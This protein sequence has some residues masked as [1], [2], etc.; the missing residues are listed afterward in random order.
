M[1][2]VSHFF[3][4]LNVAFSLGS[5]DL[6]ALGVLQ[7]VMGEQPRVKYSD[8]TASSKIGKAVAKATS[9]PFAVSASIYF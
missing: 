1:N 6:L 8:N 4:S 2:N 7:K 9:G 3:L 5:K